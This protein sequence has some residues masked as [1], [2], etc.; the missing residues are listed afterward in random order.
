MGNVP[1]K[2]ANTDNPKKTLE[3]LNDIASDL[4]LK[5]KNDLAKLLE[6]QFAIFLLTLQ[7]IPSKI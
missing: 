7:K 6:Y 2:Q 4:I 5:T 1:S 3:Y